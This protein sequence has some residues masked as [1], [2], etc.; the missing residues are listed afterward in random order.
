M[1]TFSK[2][3]I[4]TIGESILQDYCKQGRSDVIIS[5]DIERFAREYLGLD[6]HY[7][8]LSANCTIL[9]LTTYKGVELELQL[10]NHTEII[11][12]PMDTILVE[13][14]LAKPE[15]AARR[16]F[17]IAHECAHQILARL[18]ERDTGTSFR[19]AI[20]DGKYCSC[21]ELKT[22]EEWSEWQ[23]NA[24][25]AA[26]LMPQNELFLLA[27]DEFIP[28][29]FSVQGE[30]ERDVDRKEIKKIAG[31]YSVSWMAMA[32]RLKELG[33]VKI[34]PER[35]YDFYNALAI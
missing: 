31:W 26:L 24:L 20:V 11:T 33:L 32:I 35:G 19:K 25:G 2:S 21:R 16:R 13:E 14:K 27:A 8:K 17:T 12:V 23:A 34:E 5:I 4:E 29:I 9:G 30:G 7:Q 6:V 28:P 18:E 1:I 15:H 10:K 22:A 3:D